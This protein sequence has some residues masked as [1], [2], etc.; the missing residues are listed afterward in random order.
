VTV[1][2]NRQLKEAAGMKGGGKSDSP[3][4]V[5]DGR[6]VHMAKGWAED[7]ASKALTRGHEYSPRKRVKLPAGAEAGDLV[8]VR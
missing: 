6:A 8:E 4:V 5:R 7:K 3:I 1:A 2:V